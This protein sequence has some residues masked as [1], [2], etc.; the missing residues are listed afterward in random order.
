MIVIWEK[1]VK[2][3]TNFG[4][5]IEN[6]K[7]SKKN[8]KVFKKILIKIRKIKRKFEIFST[9]DFHSLSSKKLCWG[10]DVPPVRPGAAT[11]Y[12]NPEI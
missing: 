5:L 4:N 10:G 11:I 6:F 2:V 9:I 8:L 12:V 7:S 1:F 3:W